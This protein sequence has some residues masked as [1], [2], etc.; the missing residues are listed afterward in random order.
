M[1]VLALL[2]LFVAPRGGAVTVG[3]ALVFMI[4]AAFDVANLRT[5]FNAWRAARRR[6]R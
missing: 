1:V 3:L 4:A 2:S 5:R 6:A